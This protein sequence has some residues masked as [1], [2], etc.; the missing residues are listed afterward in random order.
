MTQTVSHTDTH[1]AIDTCWLH[2]RLAP[3]IFGD[4]I[5]TPAMERCLTG[6]SKALL[7]GSGHAYITPDHHPI[8]MR[9]KTQHTGERRQSITS[10][11]GSQTIKAVAV[12]ADSSGGLAT[13]TPAR[14]STKTSAFSSEKQS[15]SRG[16][17]ST[18]TKSNDSVG[19][20]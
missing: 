6:A 12:N 14:T 18:A 13:T 4:Y 2:S 5:Q 17:T 16:M 1:H 19:P 9:K 15:R 3:K 7:L 11:L 20:P 8:R 10:R